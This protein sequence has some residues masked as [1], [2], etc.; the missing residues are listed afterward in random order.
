MISELAPN[1][2]TVAA[3]QPLND[4]ICF[5]TLQAAPLL[6]KMG[7]YLS[8]YSSLIMHEIEE[9]YRKRNHSEVAIS[10]DPFAS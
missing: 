6:D 3:T 5:L 7:R 2:D 10:G 1:Q 8:D 9:S 4:R